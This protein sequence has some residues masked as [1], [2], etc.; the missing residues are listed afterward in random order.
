MSFPRRVAG[1]KESMGG[2][3]NCLPFHFVIMLAE[4][5]SIML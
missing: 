2:R 3:T 1:G 5:F 4:A